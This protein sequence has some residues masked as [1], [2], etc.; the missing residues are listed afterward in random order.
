METPKVE[1]N[2]NSKIGGAKEKGGGAGKR[3]R[4]GE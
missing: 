2:H 3:R 1:G 4:M